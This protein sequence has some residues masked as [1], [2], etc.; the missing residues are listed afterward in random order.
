MKRPPEFYANKTG[1]RPTKDGLYFIHDPEHGWLEGLR[2]LALVRW[3]FKQ[4]NADRCFGPIQ[5]PVNFRKL[6]KE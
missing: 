5:T 1:L 6:A 2:D 3:N 4:G